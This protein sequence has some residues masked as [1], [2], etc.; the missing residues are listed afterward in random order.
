MK[1]CFKCGLE[2]E[3]TQFYK[4]KEMSDGHLNKCKEC[5]KKDTKDNP[6]ANDLND[7]S[8]SKTEKGVIRHI[9]KSQVFNS[10]K[11]NMGKPLYT[12]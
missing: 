2:K 5:T 11:R 10:K 4:H 3:L 12:K 7:N 9:Y 6:R 8:Y 1:K